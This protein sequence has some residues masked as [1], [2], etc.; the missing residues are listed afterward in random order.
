MAAKSRHLL[1]DREVKELLAEFTAR[2]G[3]DIRAVLE[4]EPKI[5]K[6]D[7][8]KST[9]LIINERP[10]LF[11]IGEE[12]LPTLLFD[13]LLVRLPRL[14]VDMGAVPHVCNGADVMSPGV[15]RVEG[16]FKKGSL[17]AIVDERHGRY[18]ALGESLVNSDD[19][20]T[21]G[22]GRVVRNAHYV[23]DHVWNAAKSL[24]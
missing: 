10:L 6:L 18:L 8:P 16:S 24:R 4:T 23:G 3:V 1:K 20:R 2:F 7:F 12:T 5:E 22:R 15:V 19:L 9:L 11:R 13:E 17:V 14:T 21:K